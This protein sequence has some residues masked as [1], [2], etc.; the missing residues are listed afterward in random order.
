[1]LRTLPWLIL[2]LVQGCTFVTYELRH[3]ASPKTQ[4]ETMADARAC[5]GKVTQG[6]DFETWTQAEQDAASIAWSHC[7]RD[8]GYVAVKP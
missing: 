5:H 3:P 8:C 6:L 4:D 1:M 2:G 7:M